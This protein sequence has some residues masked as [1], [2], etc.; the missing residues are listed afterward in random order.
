MRIIGLDFGHC[1]IAAAMAIFLNG[2]FV[3]MKNLFLDGDKNTVIPA[4]V[5]YEGEI[6]NYF[7][8]SP[9]H[10]NEQVEGNKVTAVRRDLMI[11]L[12]KKIINGILEFNTEISSGEQIMLIVGCPTSGEWTSEKNRK[13]YETLIKEATGVAE[14]RVIP[15]SRAAMFSAL[16]DGKGRMISASEGA[17]VYD[18]GSST[19]DSTY[20]KTGKRCVEVSWNLG[21][22]E[23]EK[24]LRRMMCHEASVKANQ[25]GL[26]LVPIDNYANLE[27]KLRAVKEAY[28]NGE[29]DEDSSVTAWKFPT[30]EGKKLTVTLDIDDDTM[31]RALSDEELTMDVNGKLV[32]G[33][34]KRCC[35]EFFRESKLLIEKQHSV[36]EIVLTG[37]ASKMKF[38]AEYAREIFP[39]PM[40]E[41]TCAKNPSFSVSQGL[42]WVG[43]VDEMQEECIAAAKS[44]VVDSGVAKVSKLKD[45]LKSGMG[46]KIYQSVLRSMEGWANAAEDESLNDLQER[47]NKKISS[48]EDKIKCD[49]KECVNKWTSGIVQEIRIQL[50]EELKKRL[51]T[52]LAQKMI[53]PQN[54]WAS[55]NQ[56]LENISIDTDKIVNGIDVNSILNNVMMWAI[57]LAYGGLGTAILPVFGTFVGI[58]IG[59]LFASTLNDE[60]KYKARTQKVRK[61]AKDAMAKGNKKEDILRLS[62]EQIDLAVDSKV[63][64]TSVESDI[65]EMT[66]NAYEIM[67]LKFDV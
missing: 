5:E 52:T 22:R 41:V 32:T 30:V 51:G 11:L 53:M 10:F 25:K 1:E 47:M 62:N 13:E 6:F 39:K 33:S 3:S 66:R 7:K 26:E 65:E 23:I 61:K 54:I 35:K 19:A 16:A 44:A 49:N 57:I 46:E 29:L 15:E 38:V 12:F 9:K 40:Y 34:W 14:V 27:R 31:A 21:A 43:L 8:A 24:A 42:V 37:G 64:N 67:T 2:V 58:V 18:F 55:L 20:M 17:A 60:D 4:E 59:A 50:E 28:F 48:E 56:S 45:N 36:K 63:T